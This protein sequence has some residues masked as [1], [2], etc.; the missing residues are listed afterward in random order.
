MNWIRIRNAAFVILVT[1]S[2]C[3]TYHHFDNRRDW[4]DRHI[5]ID[6]MIAELQPADPTVIDKQDWNQAITAL[7][8]GFWNG[9]HSPETVTNAEL[10]ELEIRI[11]AI[12]DNDD[13]GYSDLGT[14]LRAIGNTN[15]KSQKYVDAYFPC[16]KEVLHSRGVQLE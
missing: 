13:I 15:G 16:F 8:E 1:I 6:T 11:S 5:H 2:A 12:I 14:I 10:A 4:Y 9:C 7:R 3:F